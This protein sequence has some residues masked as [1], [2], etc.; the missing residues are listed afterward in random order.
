[1]LVVLWRSGKERALSMVFIQSKEFVFSLILT[2]IAAAKIIIIY[3]TPQ[4]SK[5]FR[6]PV[7]VPGNRVLLGY[8]NSAMNA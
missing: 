4:K 5:R 7:L 6:V 8:S 2:V 3:R 1:M